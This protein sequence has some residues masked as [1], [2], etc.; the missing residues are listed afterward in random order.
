MK[1]YNVYSIKAD[2]ISDNTVKSVKESFSI[3]ALLVGPVLF[4]FYRMWREFLFYGALLFINSFLYEA[5][6]ITLEFCR[7]LYIG[8]YVYM[9]FDFHNLY[10]QRL[11][12]KGYMFKARV[13][14][15]NKL[16]LEMKLAERH[17]L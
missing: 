8:V 7:L 3:L 4:L 16:D 9:G 10:E 15:F 13:V 2:S 17:L 12:S 6:V 11:L 14:A 1:V 5:G